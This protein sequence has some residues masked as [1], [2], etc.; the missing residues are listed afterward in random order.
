MDGSSN[1]LELEP[2]VS[3]GGGRIEPMPIP[4]GVELRNRE[5]S[6]RRRIS[7]KESVPSGGME[8]GPGITGR[9]LVTCLK[10]GQ[11]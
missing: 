3:G 10:M 2:A 9:L 11:N 7:E 1:L 6:S 5:S 8:D 4:P